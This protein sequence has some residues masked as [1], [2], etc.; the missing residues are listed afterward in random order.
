MKAPK[1]MPELRNA[2][3]MILAGVCNGDL[4]N[5]TA[6][7]ALTSASRIIESVQA[8]T[9]AR[10]LAFATKSVIPAEMPLTSSFFETKAI[11]E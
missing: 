3:G 4:S 5:E 10:A 8:E 1:T 6:R 2:C 9:R 11:D 7:V